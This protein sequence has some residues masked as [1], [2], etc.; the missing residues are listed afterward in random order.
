V[1]LRLRAANREWSRG[2]CYG[3][4]R[5]FASDVAEGFS[6]VSSELQ[7]WSRLDATKTNSERSRGWCDNFEHQAVRGVTNGSANTNNETRA[8]SG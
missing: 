4:E 2:W 3:G 6:R 8:K 5:K 1:A 7:V